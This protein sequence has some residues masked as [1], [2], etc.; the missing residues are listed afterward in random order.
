MLLEAWGSKAIG[1]HGVK[2][3]RHAGGDV[4]SKSI[5]CH[6][7]SVLLTEDESV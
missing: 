2:W 4:G 6:V 7:P 3:R 1:C 5:G